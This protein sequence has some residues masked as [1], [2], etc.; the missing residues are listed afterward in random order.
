MSIE[1]FRQRLLGSEGYDLARAL[2]LDFGLGGLYSEELCL[3]SAISKLSKPRELSGNEIELLYTALSRMIKS[4]PE[5]VVVFEHGKVVD[6]L[7]FMFRLYEGK[8][9]EPYAAF[10][11]ALEFYYDSTTE[12]T[13][14]R[15]VAR[16]MKAIE[17]QEELIEKWSQTARESSEKGDAVYSNYALIM[18]II[19]G[20]NTARKKYSWDEIK[21]KLKGHKYIR[22]INEK[23]GK[24]TVEI[25]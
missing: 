10:S 11:G 17:E 8:K 15:S 22:E 12:K 4:R 7:P 5:P 23:S 16:L 13:E 21:I 1:E 2:A 20:I 19:E 24:I 3:I 14:N 6:A 9:A 25:Q 18:E